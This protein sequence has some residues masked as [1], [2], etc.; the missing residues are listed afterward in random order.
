MGKT[1]NILKGAL[2]VLFLLFVGSEFKAQG[3]DISKTIGFTVTPKSYQPFVNYNKGDNFD[4]GQILTSEDTEWGK[5][6]RAFGMYAFNLKNKLSG[7]FIK[8]RLV[9][10][11]EILRVQSFEKH[12][13]IIVLTEY[14][15][16]TLLVKYFISTSD[17]NKIDFACWW[18]DKK[19]D[20]IMG[21]ISEKI[22]VDFIQDE[23]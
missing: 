23:N 1:K 18:Y 2:I 15:G 4:L 7:F 12:T 11:G 8:D 14:E 6:K 16:E 17:E 5:K 3:V 19:G 20:A 21:E 13:I 9:G 22:E 10:T